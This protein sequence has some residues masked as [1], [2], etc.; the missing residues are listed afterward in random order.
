MLML[1]D[2]CNS[3]CYERSSEPHPDGFH[4]FSPI[5]T[6]HSAFKCLI[7]SLTPSHTFSSAGPPR[8]QTNILCY[9][10]YGIALIRTNSLPID[11]L[12]VRVRWVNNIMPI[13]NRERGE[14]I[15]GPEL[16]APA[17]ADG[18]DTTADAVVIGVLGDRSVG[19]DAVVTG[20]YGGNV[21]VDE[22]VVVAE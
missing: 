13:R 9:N 6:H 1:C 4:C 10:L 22:E 5:K 2:V 12:I 7:T 14:S 20:G 15:P 19:P 11:K 17:A 3:C 8:Q 16:A 18:E 21:R